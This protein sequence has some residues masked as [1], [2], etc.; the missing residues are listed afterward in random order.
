MDK[1]KIDIYIRY[2]N[3]FR[4]LLNEFDGKLPR[5]GSTLS[6]LSPADDFD[7]ETKLYL[8]YLANSDSYVA[9]AEYE[10]INELFP[11]N[12]LTIESC[13]R[14][15]DLIKSIN[16]GGS[17]KNDVFEKLVFIDKGTIRG[18]LKERRPYEDAFLL[19]LQL[20][21]LYEQL[22]R[23]LIAIDEEISEVEV[24]TLT[25][26]IAMMRS[27]IEVELISEFGI[28][29][30][31][32][33]MANQGASIF[34]DGD[35]EK[36]VTEDEEK[37]E[38]TLDE[39]L[40][41]LNT[42][43]GLGSVKA[44]VSSLIN[45][46]RV[47]AIR[48][49][50]GI[51]QAP[52]SMHLVFSGNPGTGKT[53]VARLLS[54]IYHALGILSSGHLVEVDRSGLV[55]GYVGQTA[56]KTQEKI[57][58]AEGG[59]LFIDEAYTL[60]KEDGQD[61]GQEAIDTILK[62]MEDKRGN[63]IVIVAGYSEPMERFLDSNPGLRSRFNKFIDFTDYT[64]EELYSIFR[65]LCDENNYICD[66]QS[67]SFS[68]KLFDLLYQRRNKNFS[69]GRMVRNLFEKTITNQANRIA[70]KLDSIDEK[71]LMTITLNDIKEAL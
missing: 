1:R 58:E 62:A 43:I 45:L 63:L 16:Y 44:D 21:Q 2:M 47:R 49:E 64:G 42:L 11:D 66:Q 9:Y 3:L 17:V 39:L 57:E 13:D 23:E 7:Y 28:T 8:L 15:V 12:P 61:Y 52:I 53:T 35:S 40:A 19:S 51:K 67:D 24:R 59:I 10:F 4:D 5:T 30:Y 31:R 70:D 26:Y 14:N 55:A 18:V 38:K 36:C 41:E 68:R 71:E 50:K 6:L 69:N 20:T 33:I 34:D 54:R 46:L 32:K 65:L 60:S 25:D 37:A 48:E 22:G 29:L 27:Y 56:I